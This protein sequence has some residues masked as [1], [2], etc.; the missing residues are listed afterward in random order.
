MFRR[1]GTAVSIAQVAV[2]HESGSIDDRV[3]VAAAGA[4]GM[5]SAT[6]GMNM[7][8]TRRPR[9]PKGGR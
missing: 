3:D 7:E 4:S 1:T 2:S 6:C 8:P 5:A 9:P